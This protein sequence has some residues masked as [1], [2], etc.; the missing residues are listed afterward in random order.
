[1]HIF[2]DFAKA[3]DTVNHKILLNKLNHYGI[4]GLPLEWLKNYLQN[5]QQYT[6]I[7]GTL[8][9]MDYIKCG[10]PQGSI[11]SPRLFHIYINDI[12]NSPSILKFFLFADDT[13]IFFSAKP[14]LSIQNTLNIE[15]SKVNTWLN[16]NKLSLNVGKSCYLK[17]SLLK[18]TPNITIKIANKPLEKKEL[19][20]ILE[21]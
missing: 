17:F 1:M 10:V 5:R 8:S 4:R 3:F 16:C 19:L 15:L 14:S 7:E 9:F 11:L 12:I 18:S 20:N 21:Y 6:D 13:T 2:L